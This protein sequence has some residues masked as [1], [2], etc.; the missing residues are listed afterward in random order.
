MIFEPSLN[1]EERGGREE[2]GDGSRGNSR[3]GCGGVDQHCMS[4]NSTWRALSTDLAHS[5]CSINVQSI[6]QSPPQSL[7]SCRVL[8]QLSRSIEDLCG[9]IISFQY[10]FLILIK[11]QNLNLRQMPSNEAGLLGYQY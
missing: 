6:E 2:E 11:A 8:S 10:F 4:R 9:C 5:K 3:A 7:A 1:M